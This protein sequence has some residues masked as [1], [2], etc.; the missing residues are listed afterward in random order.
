MKK[1][2][3]IITVILSFFVFKMNIKAQSVNVYVFHSNTC[4]HCKAAIKY[5]ESI[6]D[7]YDLNI[8]K[9][10][11]QD[12]DTTKKIEI[13]EEYFD[14]SITSVPVVIINNRHMRGYSES[15][16]DIYLYNIKQASDDDFIDEIGIKLGVVDKK[17]VKEKKD[18]A[19]KISFLGKK[20]VLNKRDNLKNTIILGFVKAFN[21]VI[22]ISSFTLLLIIMILNKGYKYTLISIIIDFIIY[23]LFGSILSIDG[24]KLFA[25]SK[26][27]IV[28]LL[29]G[30]SLYKIND[31]MSLYNIKK[32]D[33]IKVLPLILLIVFSIFFSIIKVFEIGFIPNIISDTSILYKVLYTICYIVI[34]VICISFIY[35]IIKITKLD[36]YKYNKLIF[37]AI[38]IIKPTILGI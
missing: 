2:L 35:L 34:N 6:K 27:I 37:G 24:Y 14:V 31:E 17:E 30:I 18:N 7:K 12:P 5:L 4:N 15:T 25:L 32:L 20:I 1:F 36:K 8:Y 11:V 29:V 28:L 16:N 38:L 21:P 10:E 19:Y 23:I 26:L 13:V 9:Y 3:L 33:K 22:I